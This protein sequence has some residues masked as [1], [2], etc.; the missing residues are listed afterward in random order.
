MTG[1]I[2]SVFLDSRDI[3]RDENPS[4]AEIHHNFVSGDET[5][6]LSLSQ[7]LQQAE[8]FGWDLSRRFACSFLGA[9]RA[10]GSDAGHR[11]SRTVAFWPG[12]R[13]I[14]AP[15]SWHRKGDNVQSRR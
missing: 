14:F 8:S 15:E 6:L 3:S 13:F 4:V 7:H 11:M 1:C 12:R 10:L 9:L 2:I 5:R